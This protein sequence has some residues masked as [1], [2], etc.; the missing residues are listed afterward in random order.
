[1]WRLEQAEA[2]SSGLLGYL[3]ELLSGPLPSVG[4]VDGAGA[5]AETCVTNVQELIKFFLTVRWEMSMVSIFLEHK[6]EIF[7]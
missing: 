4:W 7:F 3:T 1:M 2:F 6:G 5:G